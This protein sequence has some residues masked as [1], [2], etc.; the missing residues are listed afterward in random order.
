MGAKTWI[1]SFSDGKAKEV[2]RSL[3]ISDKQK[4][5]ELLSQLFPS[6]KFE[7]IDDTDLFC[8]SPP[9]NE[10]Y[11]G[12]YAGLTIVAA[13]DFAIDYPS[14]IPSHYLLDGHGSNIHLHAMHS[15][16]DWVAFA[17][18]ENNEL[19]RSLSVSPD[20][21]IIED[22]GEQLSFEKPYWE[23]KHPAV[24]P[25]DEDEYPLP[26]HPLE[27]GEEALVE[28]YGFQLE[29]ASDKQLFEPEDVTLSAYKKKKSRWKL[30]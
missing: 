27:L 19:K 9:D 7:S 22:I 16:V 28:F 1:L 11:L 12:C 25:E 23:G 2:L 17:V 13:S 8:T 29:G 3:P 21:G 10:I 30:W 24:D 4:E 5:Q 20:G 26:F 6:E 18:W 15:V 14:Q